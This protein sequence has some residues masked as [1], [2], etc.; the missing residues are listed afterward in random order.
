MNIDEIRRIAEIM[1]KHDLS[2]FSMESEDCKMK[3]RRGAK[4]VGVAPPHPSAPYFAPPYSGQAGVSGPPPSGGGAS[5]DNEADAGP[6]GTAEGEAVKTIDSPIVGTFY[7]APSPDSENFVKEGDEVTPETVV[8]IIEA[9]KVM[10][11]IKAEVSGRVKKVLVE[12]AQPVE[13]GQPL[14]ELE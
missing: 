5:S 3:V 9:M 1:E 11:E 2:E 10:N 12:N 4:H 6:S 7:R 13:F 14:F 8:C